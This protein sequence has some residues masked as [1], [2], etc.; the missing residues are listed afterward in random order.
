[1]VEKIA[2]GLPAEAYRALF[3]VGAPRC[4]T[5]ALS[6]HIAKHPQVCFAKP[7]ET[8]FFLLEPDRGDPA[9]DRRR[10]LE[11]H[12]PALG[13]GH[14]TVADGSVSY[15]YAPEAARRAARAFPGARFVVGLRRPADL[16][17]SFHARMVYMT[18]E[19]ETGFARAWSL[20]AERAAG[21]RIPRGC[22]EPRLLQY[23]EVGRLGTHLERLF[24]EVGRDAVLVYLFDDLVRDPLAVYGE[25]LRFMGLPPDP[26]RPFKAARG[27]RAFRHRW[28]RALSLGKIGLP[29]PWLIRLYLD[30]GGWIRPALRPLRRLVK[31]RNT[32]PAPAEPPLVD[33]GL[34]AELAAAFAPEV[35]RLERLLGRDLS[36]WR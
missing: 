1:M 22:R 3:I 27:R 25:I 35:E 24:E 9:A 23:R 31:E 12:F 6:K 26:P 30:H 34:E 33:N 16:V 13:P 36:A 20:Q 15:L 8:H 21:R 17:R 19:D 7:K 29:L 14:T 32:R 18:E 28:L 2:S 4:G 10:F 11:R 5:T